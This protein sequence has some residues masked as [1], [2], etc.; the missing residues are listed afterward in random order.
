MYRI[1]YNPLSA[2][3]K[4]KALAKN[5]R[6]H[7]KGESYSFCDM[8]EISDYK[9]YFAK[10]EKDDAIVITGGDGTLN[11][12]INDTDGVLPDIDVYYY[13]AGSGN[14]FYHDISAEPNKLVKINAYIKDLPIVEVN[15]KKAR[16]LNGIGYGIDG[17]CCEEGDKIGHKTEKPAN[18]TAIAIKGLLF[19]YKPTNAK[20]TVDGKTYEFSKVWLAPT[21]NG[22]F[23]GGGMMVTPMQD[24]LCEDKTLSVCVLHH[25]GKLKTLAI[26]PS[27][28]KGEHIKHTDV[29]EFLTGHEITVEFDRPTALQIDGETVVGVTSYTVHSAALANKQVEE[30]TV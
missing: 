27:I 17:Y 26:F 12:F 4:G 13:P 29:F 2:H 28:F 6:E 5:V 11:R 24:R 19:H 8:R 1:L 22:R 30:A 9:A 3:G 21:M 16:F 7:L 25:S 23:Y 14:D 10:L 15:G 18:Y 20:V